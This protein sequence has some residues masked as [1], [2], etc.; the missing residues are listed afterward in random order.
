MYEDEIKEELF[1]KIVEALNI[2]SKLEGMVEGSGL[3]WEELRKSS[4]GFED[5]DKQLDKA[6][7][8]MNLLLIDTRYFPLVGITDTQKKIF[9]FVEKGDIEE[10]HVDKYLDFTLGAIKEDMKKRLQKVKPI[11]LTVHV[12]P[13]TS[14]LYT[15]AIKC[16][17]NG[18]FE[19]SCVL[20]R[21]ITESIAKRYVEYKGF[22]N[23][24]S[25]KNKEDKKMSIP[26]I[27]R[28]KLSI[29]KE[30][31]SIYKKI[32]NKANNILHK[33]SDKTEEKDAL[34]AI[35]LLQSFIEKFP[36]TL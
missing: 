13:R 11:Y 3:S 12:D 20:C 32:G 16:Y 10:R 36:K 5:L 26:E 15:Q 31:L 29:P 34:N 33:K 23:S 6:I 21:A 28:T 30:I 22:G 18:A 4:E 14:Y 27:L 25:G 8:E 7:D 19:A 35:E 2:M 9:S 1:K 24:L 17:I